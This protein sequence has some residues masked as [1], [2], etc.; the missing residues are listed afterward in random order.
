MTQVGFMPFDIFKSIIDNN[1]PY[2]KGYMFTNGN[3][4][5][6]DQTYTKTTYDLLAVPYILFQEEGTKFFQGNVDFIQADTVNELNA[7]A[8]R[9]AHGD[10]SSFGDIRDATR[11]KASLVSNGVMT[12]VKGYGQQ[13]GR[14]DVYVSRS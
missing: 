9:Y 4:Y 8:A 7:T 11:K 10:T 2:D 14:Y 13:G 5:I 6:V 1:K 12:H 3:R